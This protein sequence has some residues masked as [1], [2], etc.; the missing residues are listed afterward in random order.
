M[1]SWCLPPGSRQPQPSSPPPCIHP[2]VSASDVH[3]VSSSLLGP[4]D[5]SFR[6]LSGRLKFTVWRHKFNKDALSSY[7]ISVSA[8]LRPAASFLRARERAR[9]QDK[10]PVIEDKIPVAQDKVA[11]VQDRVTTRGDGLRA[12][13][14]FHPAL[15]SLCATPLSSENGTYKTVKG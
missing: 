12:G 9:V 5:P 11:V 15:C 1:G 10:L 6:A 8:C 4:V 13:A 14:G 2:R 3:H 7:E